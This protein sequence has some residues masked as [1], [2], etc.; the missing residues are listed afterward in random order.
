MRAVL[1]NYCKKVSV[2]C[3]QREV[4][5]ICY[6]LG[7]EGSAIDAVHCPCIMN[8]DKAVHTERK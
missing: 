3:S 6:V 4:R 1:G 8:D 2:A 7:T 5:V